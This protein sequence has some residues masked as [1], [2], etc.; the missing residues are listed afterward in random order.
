MSFKKTFAVF[1]REW[2]SSQ[3]GKETESECVIGTGFL[4]LRKVMCAGW[5]LLSGMGSWEVLEGHLVELRMK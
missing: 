5:A 3:E 2:S 4:L 1:L